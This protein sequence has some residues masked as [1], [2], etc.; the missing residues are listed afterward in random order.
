MPSSAPVGFPGSPGR[1][2]IPAHARVLDLGCGD[3]LLSSQI[4]KLRAD[5][6]RQGIEI[7]VRNKTFISVTSILAMRNIMSSIEIDAYAG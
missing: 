4:V 6:P 1:L 7:L 2:L 3:R 5:V